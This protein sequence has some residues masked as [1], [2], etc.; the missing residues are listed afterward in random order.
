MNFEVCI[1]LTNLLSRQPTAYAKISHAKATTC[2]STKSSSRAYGE[3]Y[4]KG[5]NGEEVGPS[6]FARV[7]NQISIM[8][9]DMA[10]FQGGIL[11]KEA[12][13]GEV[14]GA[15]GVSGAAGDEDEYCALAGVKRCTMANALETVP[16]KHSCKTVKE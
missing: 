9:G 11:V 5:P 16:S 4:L 3:K 8:N 7:I 12:S 1:S 13:T 6:V 14:V 10:A 2:V 15:V